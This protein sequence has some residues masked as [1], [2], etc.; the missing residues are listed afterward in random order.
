[1]KRI[2]TLVL[3][4]SSAVA[5]AQNEK[6]KVVTDTI[7][8]KI[9]GCKRAYN[10]YLPQN[11][12][13]DKDKSYPVLYLLHGYS[14]DNTNWTKRGHVRDVMINLVRAGEVEEMIIVMPNAGKKAEETYAC[15]GYFNHPHWKYE[16]YFFQELMPQVEAKYRIKADRQHRAIAGLSMGGG[17]TISYAQ[18]HPE[19]F[20]AAYAMS[21]FMGTP[22]DYNKE[23]HSN[24]DT[25]AFVEGAL[26]HDC[27]KYVNE[28]TKSQLEG[29]K[30][31]KWY[32]DC[33][34]DDYLLCGNLNFILAMKSRGVPMQIRIREGAHNWE[35]WNSALYIALPFFSRNF[36]E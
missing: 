29:L 1:M 4:L 17:G 28:A 34:D 20:C 11:Y 10:I 21:A 8:S 25:K 35:Y 9:L 24:P 18:R 7:S 5:F 12:N 6:S 23:R 30:S 26:R 3:L 2:L 32:L 13:V 14:D 31:I 19:L 36:G 16:D 33:G 27:V 15:H 22:E